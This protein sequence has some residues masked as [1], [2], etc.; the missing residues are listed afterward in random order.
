MKSENGW[1]SIGNERP[2][3]TGLVLVTD[4]VAVDTRMFG[5]E[6]AAFRPVGFNG[7][8]PVHAITDWMRIK[9]PL[10][11]DNEP[12]IP[13]ASQC[14]TSKDRVLF[15]DGTGFQVGVWMGHGWFM[16]ERFVD[17]KIFRMPV[18]IHCYTYPITHWMHLPELPKVIKV[19]DI[20]GSG[21]NRCFARLEAVLDNTPIGHL[22]GEKP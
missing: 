22:C 10:D 13:M 16:S 20:C 3:N 7:C 1:V 17:G 6:I 9:N 21:M 15:F 18:F 14:P 8:I 4:G 19:G 11:T 5:Q 2:E 12:W